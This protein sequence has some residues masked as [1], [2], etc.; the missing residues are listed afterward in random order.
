MCQNNEYDVS[1][2]VYSFFEG[3]KFFKLIFEMIFFLIFRFINFPVFS[4]FLF[5]ISVFSP[6]KTYGYAFLRF[7]HDN[8]YNCNV[9]EKKI[10][11]S[12]KNFKKI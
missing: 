6:K 2:E 5:K 8:T 7:H 12:S 9:S 1:V 4:D 11:T 10:G 3:L